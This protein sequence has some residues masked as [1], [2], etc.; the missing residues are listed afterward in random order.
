M[1]QEPGA[2]QNTGEAGDQNRAFGLEY[3]ICLGLGAIVLAIY[4]QSVWFDFVTFDDAMYVYANPNVS[5]GLTADNL[6]QAFTSR[7]GGNWHPLTS[8]SHM[9]DVELF[10]L[11]PGGHHL[12]N[13]LLHAATAVVIFLALRRLTDTLWPSAFCVAVFAVHPLR[14]ESVA[15]IAERK[16]VLSG[17]FFALTLLTYAWYVRRRSFTR[18]GL[19]A[20]MAALGLMAKPMLVTIPFVLL[21]LDYWPLGRFA[22]TNDKPQSVKW[23]LLEKAPLLALSAACCAATVWAQNEAIEAGGQFSLGDRL[24][25]GATAYLI[26]I[27]QTFWPSGLI[28]FYP[29]PKDGLPNGEVFTACAALA[30]VTA[31]LI[32]CRST[33]A[34]LAR[35][36]VLVLGDAGPRDR[37]RA[38]RRT[39]ACGPL[40]LLAADRPHY[41]PGLVDD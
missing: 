22:A 23:L 11:R 18:Y 19:V 13:V 27:R 3:R 26:Y 14:V 8:L 34:V 20:L 15:W 6:A 5:R 17:L 29:H 33:P 38:G 35:R 40:Y 9:L 30:A 2:N 21:L 31:S 32:I 39:G 4:A 12:I 25:N 36:L 41:R 10:E 37:P 7:H 24:A 28:V 16:D 1:S